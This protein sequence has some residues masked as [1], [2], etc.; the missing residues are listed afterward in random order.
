MNRA[1]PPLA[2]AILLTPASHLE[3]FQL[4]VTW[5][6]TTPPHHLRSMDSTIQ[7]LATSNLHST[8][9]TWIMEMGTRTV[10]VV[11]VKTMV[12][13]T[14]SMK[15]LKKELIIDFMVGLGSD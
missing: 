10:T 9:S 1:S 8:R 7:T 13:K 6:S 12:L 14:G 15:E 5:L 11:S 4:T 3:D 2:K